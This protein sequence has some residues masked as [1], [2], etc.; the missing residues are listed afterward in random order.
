MSCV[1]CILQLPRWLSVSL[2]TGSCRGSGAVS[3]VRL[4][5]NHNNPGS[6]CLSPSC[7][8]SSEMRGG[9]DQAVT[10]VMQHREHVGYRHTVTSHCG[11]T[12]SPAA[13]Q[14]VVL[15]FQEMSRLFWDRARGQQRKTH[16]HL[17]WRTVTCEVFGN[18]YGVLESGKVWID[19]LN[20]PCPQ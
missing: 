6:P 14:E 19:S 7:V 11:E 16:K 13:R 12:W 3:C 9:G 17:T 8:T 18:V 10:R 20:E 5:P 15:Q 2:Y 1:V 4:H